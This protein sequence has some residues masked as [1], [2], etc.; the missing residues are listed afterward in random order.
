MSSSIAA[1]LMGTIPIATICITILF[2]KHS[3]LNMQAIAGIMTGFTGIVILMLPNIMSQTASIMDILSI[4]LSSI[5]FAISLILIKFLSPIN[6]I[7]HMRNI[8][9]IASLFLIIAIMSYSNPIPHYSLKSL[10]ALLI[11]G[12][13]CTGFVYAVFITLIQRT[14]TVFASMIN[15]LIPVVG[16]IIGNIFMHDQ[17]TWNTVLSLLCILIALFQIRPISSSDILQ[18]K[19][20]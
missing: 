15:Y 10:V 19:E 18:N 13:F 2:I 9:G 7:K 5:S 11:L 14:T 1:I 3:K 8:L 4:S 16:V 20:I 17:I 12:I 6:S